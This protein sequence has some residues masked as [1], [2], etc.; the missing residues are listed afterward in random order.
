M[1][2]RD[3]RCL[4]HTPFDP[5]STKT[6]PRK[7]KTQQRFKEKH[8]NMKTKLG[9]A[10]ALKLSV[11]ALAMATPLM[12]SADSQLDTGGTGSARARLNISVVIPR[13]LFLGV[14]DGAVVGAFGTTVDNVNT[15]TFD[16]SNNPQDVGTTAAAG[17]IGN[18]VAGFT[19]GTVPVKVWGN[20]GQ[21]TLT[22]STTVD[23]PTSGT[24]VIPWTEFTISSSSADLNPPAMP[25]SGTTQT[26]QPTVNGG[27]KITNQ[28]ADWTFSYGNN[29]PV[30]AGTYT[31]QLTYTA[32]ML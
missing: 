21:V 4:S 13:V 29:N 5:R 25:D 1:Q 32:S 24:D 10:A 11:L 15:L 31:G 9:T 28:R 8:M 3:I 20:N 6:R 23:G 7:A 30:A 12:A 19:G 2:A 22:A 14:G 18:N 17:S 26:S 27:S 16:Y